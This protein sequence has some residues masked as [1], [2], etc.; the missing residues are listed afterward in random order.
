[1]RDSWYQLCFASALVC[2]ARERI[3]AILMHFG[4]EA[5][6]AAVDDH[7]DARVRAPQKSPFLRCAATM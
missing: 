4:L 6:V 2:N 1:M 5:I 3:P 7:P